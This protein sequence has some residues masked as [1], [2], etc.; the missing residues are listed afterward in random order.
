MSEANPS[1]FSRWPRH[2]RLRFTTSTL[3]GLLTVAGIACA[4]VVAVPWLL[5]LLLMVARSAVLVAYAGILVS[6]ACSAAGNRRLFCIAALVALVLLYFQPD[7][8]VR[9]V[10]YIRSNFQ[11]T[12]GVTLFTWGWINALLTI[13]LS[14]ASGWIAV[15]AQQ[16]WKSDQ[17]SSFRP[18]TPPAP[19]KVDV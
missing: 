12:S 2:P 8:D 1:P 5:L 10:S 16:F 19:A 11:V 7:A 3:L 14:L 9:I 4:L 6:G 17:P 15:Q 18:D 13:G